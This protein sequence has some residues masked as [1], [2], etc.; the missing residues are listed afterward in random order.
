MN[1]SIGKVFSIHYAWKTSRLSTRLEIT[2]SSYR[3]PLPP[4]KQS[5]SPTAIS[6]SF[7]GATLECHMQ[8]PIDRSKPRYTRLINHFSISHFHSKAAAAP[9]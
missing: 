1:G 8:A 5:F 7:T 2:H 9:K 6:T 4:R 3:V